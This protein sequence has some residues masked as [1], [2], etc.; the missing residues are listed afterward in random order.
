LFAS[1]LV[2]EHAALHAAR[3]AA[4]VVGDDPAR[5]GNED[6]HSIAPGGEREQMVRK[7]VILTLAPLIL[8]G[9]VE[10]VELVF[11]DPDIPGGGAQS[12]V[13]E[14]APMTETSVAKVRTRVE[15][16][17]VC[18]IG[19]ANK[20]ACPPDGLGLDSIFGSTYTRRIGAE[21]IYPYQGAR[22][23]Y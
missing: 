2:T 10:D 9:L 4:V 16:R 18:R 12:D 11:P 19:F 1:K 3:A 22:Y 20:I 7:A 13:I 14:Y 21:A 5:Y 8:T 17:V 23:E 6:T 15:V